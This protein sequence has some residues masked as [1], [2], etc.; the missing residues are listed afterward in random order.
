MFPKGI[1]KQIFI[2]VLMFSAA[3]AFGQSGE[4]N[5]HP[6]VAAAYEPVGF[7]TY[8]IATK[9]FDLSYQPSSNWAFSLNYAQGETERL[10]ATYSAKVLLI[11]ARWLIGDLTYVNIGM[12]TRTAGYQ[13]TSSVLDSTGEAISATTT[14]ESTSLV[15]ELSLGT[16]VSFGP[17]FVGCDWIG[18]MMP[19]QRV[20]SKKAFPESTDEDTKA[21]YQ[22]DADEIANA[23]NSEFMRLY[24][25]FGF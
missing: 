5:D 8:P 12:G 19:L 14:I 21:H 2:F 10:L 4:G 16:R 20:S 22:E 11:R 24:I 9:A 25:G 3:H 18:G 15:G 7:A 6:T 1:A 23:P 17:L 13:R